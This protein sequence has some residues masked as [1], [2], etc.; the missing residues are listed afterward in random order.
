MT[1]TLTRGFARTGESITNTVS[2][3]AASEV[4][5]DESIAN[6]ATNVAVTWAVDQSELKLLYIVSDKA[7]TL[8]TNS[9]SAPDD[10]ITLAANQPVEWCASDSATCPLSADVTLLYVTNSSGASAAL[11]IRA[12]QDPTP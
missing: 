1:H 8:K 3:T 10:T 6:G 12:L 9:S 4:N 2:Q 5:V 7:L 11:T